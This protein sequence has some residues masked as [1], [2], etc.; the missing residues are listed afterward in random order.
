MENKSKNQK[1]RPVKNK[2]SR[3]KK[4]EVKGGSFSNPLWCFSGIPFVPTPGIDLLPV[5]P[6]GHG[7]LF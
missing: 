2:T 1:V 5:M 3:I 4:K 6:P 7:G